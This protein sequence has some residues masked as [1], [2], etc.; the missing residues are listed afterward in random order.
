MFPVTCSTSF[1]WYMKDSI[2]LLVLY[3]KVKLM[4]TT[5][6][7]ADL[8]YCELGVL[9]VLQVIVELMPLTYMWSN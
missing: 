4:N 6:T 1:G 9:I 2:F 8:F 7:S 5:K 3:Y